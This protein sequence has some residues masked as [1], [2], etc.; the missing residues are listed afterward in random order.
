MKKYIVF[1]TMALAGAVLVASCDKNEPPVFDDANAFVAFSAANVTTDESKALE[2]GTFAPQGKT[3]KLAVTLASVKGLEETIKYTVVD[4]VNTFSKKD[5]DG[6][7]IDLT[8]HKG[9]NFDLVSNT[10]TLS[11]DAE[12][13]TQYIEFYTIYDGEYTGDLKFI[14]NLEPSD[15]VGLGYAGSVTITISDVDHPLGFLLGDYQGNYSAEFDYF[16]GRAC[17]NWPV[18]IEKD[19][20]SLTTVWVNDLEP[21]FYSAGFK[22]ATGENSYKGTLNDDMTQITIE[23]SQ[24]TGYKDVVLVGYTDPD[25]DEGSCP[26]DIVLE[27]TYDGDKVV[28]FEI[29]N[30]YG[31]CIK[32]D[33]EGGWYDL[34][35]GGMT[36]V[37]L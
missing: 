24:P 3:V 26:A 13:R 11:F 29:P 8:A 1:I 36:F 10:G 17:G 2:D 32:D 15:A 31:A 12:N 16:G 21:Y 19:P 4:T 37:K 18:R 7:L 23:H 28:G 6:K 22:A 27:L 34:I 14:I 25:V 9:V 5:E 30:G 33:W 35:Y 20:E